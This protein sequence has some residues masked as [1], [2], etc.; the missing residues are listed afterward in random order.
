MD[1]KEETLNTHFFT[2]FHLQSEHSVN[3]NL[4]NLFS[5]Y[6]SLADCITRQ[7][8]SKKNSCRNSH[9]C[10]KTVTLIITA[11]CQLSHNNPDTSGGWAPNY[12]LTFRQ[13]SIFIVWGSS[14][15]QDV[16]LILF[17]DRCSLIGGEKFGLSK[18]KFTSSKKKQFQLRHFKICQ[19]L[20]IQ[21]IGF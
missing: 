17:G 12:A 13:M 2:M 7:W 11:A 15:L 14:K 1:I 16:W 10:S 3:S 8:K 5:Y 18:L 6:R 4:V 9:L 21:I 19:G 20:K